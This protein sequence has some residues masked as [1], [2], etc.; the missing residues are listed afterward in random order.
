MADVPVDTAVV[1]SM[2]VDTVVV[3][4]VVVVVVVDTAAVLQ[5]V[6][7]EPTV[8]LSGPNLMGL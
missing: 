8:Q 3:D 7:A 6:S 2:A 5:S 1:D 4:I